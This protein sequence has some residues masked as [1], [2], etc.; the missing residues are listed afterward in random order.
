MAPVLEA[1]D[2][3][4]LARAIDWAGTSERAQ[5]E[6][7]NVTNGDVFSWQNVWPAIADA[8]GMEPGGPSPQSLAASMPGRAAEWD[9]IRTEHG[10]RSPGMRDFVGESFHYADFCMAFGAQDPLPPVL[11]S[12]VKLRQAGFGEALDT[13]AMFGKWFEAFQ[14]AQLLPPR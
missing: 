4:L 12:T 9:A 2:A 14:T 10:L 3:D 11:V 5:G 1:V 7:F 8:L 13:E 6:V